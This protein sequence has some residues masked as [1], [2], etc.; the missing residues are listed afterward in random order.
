METT[1]DSFFFDFKTDLATKDFNSLSKVSSLI[2]S[3]LRQQEIFFFNEKYKMQTFLHL[4]DCKFLPML[5]GPKK[6]EHEIFGSDSDS[7]PP[8]YK[9]V[10]Y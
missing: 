6:I 8:V 3:L 10:K 9:R 4:K 2:D 5:L 1:E 7:D